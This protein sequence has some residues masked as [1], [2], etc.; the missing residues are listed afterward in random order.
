MKTKHGIVRVSVILLLLGIVTLPVI[1]PAGCASD[2]LSGTLKENQPPRVWLSLA[3][4]EGSVGGYEVDISWGG[5]DPDGE[6]AYYEYAITNNEGGVFDPADTTGA[7][8]WHR[9]YGN[10]ST[11][12]FTA[13]IPAD[14]SDIDPEELKPVEFRRSHTF[15]IRAVDDRGL[16][17]RKP[18]YRS[19]TSKTLSPVVDILVPL[20]TWPDPAQVSRVTTF[21]WEGQDYVTTLDEIQEPDSVRWILVSTAGFDDSWEATLD[22]I[23]ANPDAPEWSA[24]HDYQAP[25]GAGRSWTTPELEFGRYMFAVQVM[26]EAGAVSPVYDQHRNVR[27]VLV[28]TRTT[29]PLVA[30]FNKY[31]GTILSSSS[32]TPLMIVDIPGGLELEM[33]FTADA[34]HYGGVVSG[35]RYGWD[36]SWP[37]WTPYIGETTIRLPPE[38]FFFDS[39]TFTLEVMD[40]SEFIT[41]IWI[42]FNIVPFTMTKNLLV[43]DDWDEGDLGFE[44]TNGGLPSDAEH[45][46]FWVEVLSDL[47]GFD[48]AVDIIEVRDN[49]PINAIADYKSIVWIAGGA[50]P[51][52]GDIIEFIDPRF[53]TP[54]GRISPNIIAMYMAAGGH[55]FLCGETVMTHAIKEPPIPLGV[56]VFPI[57]FR[58]ELGGDQDGHYEDS[59]VGVRGIGEDSFAYDEAC[60][61]V[62]DLAYVQNPQQRRRERDHVCGVDHLRDDDPRTNGLRW[63]LPIEGDFP[64]LELRPE[65]AGPGKSYAEDRMGLN[66]DIYN[67]EYFED[68]CPLLA[69]TDPPRDCFYPIYGHGCLDPNSV[70]FYAP[71]AYWTS[72]FGDRVPDAGGVA[73]RSVLWGFHPVYFNPDQVKQAVDVILFDEWLLPRK[74]PAPNQ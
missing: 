7:D 72:R 49:L 56:P 47:D 16:A 24:W 68:L 66:C 8:K 40:N 2:E 59:Q 69:E 36:D 37:E 31:F 18:E 62:L 60:L 48:P 28:A 4:P 51:L 34:S 71:V 23:R 58:Y 17:S 43:V 19:F 9:V 46:A 20:D 21:H 39:H 74:A 26:D 44:Q 10:D 73:A 70:I 22:Y 30:L 57:I 32:D 25:Q 63:T 64:Q 65:V 6:I 42:R 3:P 35:Y 61:N 67:P 41:R 15:F 29:G 38:T 45:D 11:F 54:P 55:V 14:S 12:N 52:L 27:R 50:D 5:W 1:G 53:P 13:D 33:R